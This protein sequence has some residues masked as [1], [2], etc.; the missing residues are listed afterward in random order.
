MPNDK[1]L[2][3]GDNGFI[4]SAVA[5]LLD[6]SGIEYKGVSRSSGYDLKDPRTLDEVISK[7]QFTAIINCAAHVG[8]IG[9]GQKYSK[10]ILE[11]NT[12]MNL[13][14]VTAA[15][16]FRLKLVNPISNCA[17]PGHLSEYRESHFWDG[18]V[19]ESV[20]A[21]ATTRRFLVDMSTLYS[22]LENFS[23]INIAIPNT[24]GPGDHLDPL[25][26]H[27][28]GGM[29]YRA[30]LSKKA[31]QKNFTVWGSGKPIREWIFVDDVAT[32][33]VNSLSVETSHSLIN[34]GSGKGVSIKDLASRILEAIDFQGKLLF[35][36]EK[37]D[38]ANKKIM[39][40]DKGPTIL[41]WEPETNF[42]DGLMKTISWYERTI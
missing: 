28:L 14:I 5:K 18:Q 29:I 20:F 17:Y 9:Y 26:A 23:V 11:D 30:L 7:N 3:L 25:R 16:R 34:I 36:L 22:K 40:I 32:A 31:N 35:D 21:Y 15:A 4:G 13:N 38:G 41:N 27:A 19:H 1:V 10:L 33:L 2:L 42:E 8:G 39:V 37:P 12:L 6:S 24:F